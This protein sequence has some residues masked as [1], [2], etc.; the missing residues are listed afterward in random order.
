MSKHL[1]TLAALAA[2]ALFATVVTAGGPEIKI[3]Q[4]Y[5]GG[6]N[7]GASFNQD[8]VEIF[9]AGASTV[10][11]SGWSV[12]Y[13]SSSGSSWGNGTTVI[14]SGVSL[15][16]GQ[17]YLIGG[18][19]GA[20]GSALPTPDLAGSTN[21]SGSHGKL[22]LISDANALV[23]DCPVGGSIIDFVGYGDDPNCFEGSG[24]TGP[25]PG[26]NTSA[27]FRDDAGCTDT[28]DNAADF[29]TAAALPRNTASPVHACSA[30]G[31]TLSIADISQAEG[32]NAG[33][34]AF[35]VSLSQVAGGT[36]TV[37]IATADGSA[38]AGSDYSAASGSLSFAPGET[39][40][41]F[42]V[43]ILGDST[44][45]PD[46]SFSVSL[47]NPVGALL[48]DGQATGTLINDD[49][50]VAE[51]FE[52]QGNG[53]VSPLEGMLVRL[54]DN[55]VTAV[56]PAGF[57]VQ[58]PDQRADSD[59]ST[60]NGVY[61]YT[62]AP[63]AVNLRDSVSFDAIV[64]EFFDFTELKDLSGLAIT[65]HGN[66]LPQ[67]VLFDGMTPSRDP[68][69]L[70][71]GSSNFECFE[72]MR[73]S[74]ID[75]LVTRA[76]QNFGSDPFA[77]LT[78]SARGTR[79]LREPGLLFGLSV[80][81]GDNDAAGVWDGNPE[82]FEMD[83]DALLGFYAGTAISAGSSF[84]GTGV[85]GY[86]FGDYEFWPQDIYF[87]Y[88]APVPRTVPAGHADMLRIGNYN[89]QRLC[90]DIDDVAAGQATYECGD[91]GLPSTAEYQLKTARISQYIGGVLG[92]PDVVALEEVENLPVLDTLASRLLADYGIAYSAFLV[93]GNDPGGIDVGFLVDES[94][95]SVSSVTQLAASEMWTDPDDN[96]SKPLHDRPPLLLDASF[97]GDGS[98]N[99]RFLVMVNHLKSR[100]DVD[101]GNA[102][103]ARDSEKRLRQSVSVA[104][105]VQGIQTEPA[106]SGVPLLLVGDFN[107]YQFTDGFV[108]M[109]A[110]ISG[111]YDFAANLYDPEDFSGLGS[112]SNI[113]SP[114]L[115]DAIESLPPNQRYSY[116]YTQNFGAIQGFAERRVP[117][118]Q[119]IDHALLNEP[120]RIWFARIDFGRANVDAADEIEE[121]STGAI[122]SSDHEGFVVQLLFDR[123][124]AD[125]FEGN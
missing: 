71:C 53:D 2:T 31:P 75:G 51:I 109:V 73:V 1:P 10:D 40:K 23:G 91:N 57:V 85:I 62:G 58:T 123:I 119:V 113:V 15:A 56:G 48:G 35:T 101:D 105:L 11:I 92:L 20:T 43:A 97:V 47:G 46:E 95:V 55:I 74:I 8:F 125:G 100:S 24:P 115:W 81:A 103:A 84:L 54:A 98:W 107:S 72:A 66:P 89:V 60:S 90:D 45:E 96:T 82:V 52:I 121:N 122:G 49:A 25:V 13:A 9:N 32:G 99:E 104:H 106:S 21:M 77:E 28:D 44:V 30:A 59:P 5:G 19:T 50:L 37:D 94:R 65:S 78:I 117:T 34:M 120:A 88:R 93:E 124:F 4:V 63:P 114:P 79:S 69:A 14:G 80:T 29:A 27:T 33:N 83:L 116:L 18:A 112:N 87:D 3:S 26:G 102:E 108:D 7:S 36:V 12:Q 61:V 76:N 70:S 42:P 16:P 22:A 67:A 6:G 68:A 64:D 39:S 86:E 118:N 17:Y 110:M 38:T 41:E 111:D